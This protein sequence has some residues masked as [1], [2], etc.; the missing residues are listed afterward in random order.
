MSI[1]TID[2]AELRSL[3]DRIEQL[4]KETLHVLN[5]A[6]ASRINQLSDEQRQAHMDRFSVGDKVSFT[7][8]AGNR[9]CATVIRLNKKTASLVTHDDKRWNVAPGLLTLETE[10][11]RKEE[12]TPLQKHQPVELSVLPGGG[13][14]AGKRSPSAHAKDCEWVGGL[15]EVPDYVMQGDK[16]QRPATIVWVDS[17]GMIQGMTVCMPGEESQQI[18]S[19]LDEAFN[20]PQIGQPRLPTRIRTANMEMAKRLQNHYDSIEVVIAATPELDELQNSMY[21][22]ANREQSPLTYLAQGLQAGAIASFFNSQ[23]MLYKAAPWDRIPTDEC[24]FSVTIESLNVHNSVL[25]VIGQAGMDFGLLL[26]DSIGDFELY[27][28]AGDY[29]KRQA[30]DDSLLEHFHYR[31]LTF[32][33][34]AEIDDD[35]RKEIAANNWPVANAHAYPVL[36]TPDTGRFIRPLTDKDLDVFDALAQAVVYAL[37]NIA[38]LKKSW[39]TGERF[40]QKIITT[41]YFGETVV[42]LTTPFAYS[43]DATVHTSAIQKMATLIRSTGEFDWG[44]HDILVEEICRKFQESPECEKLG[45]YAAHCDLLMRFTQDYCEETIATAMPS[46]IEEVLFEVFP[47]KVMMNPADAQEVILEI[48]ALYHFLKR[49]FA[50][51]QA[52]A[53]LQLLSD[54]S[55]DRLKGALSDPSKA[56]M[57][58]S[59]LNFAADT[60]FDIES[61]ERL[62][63]FMNEA[64]GMRIPDSVIPGLEPAGKHTD[65]SKDLNKRKKKRKTSRKAQKKNR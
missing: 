10:T 32:E 65:A 42:E 7:D 37:K 24:L 22:H 64:Q 48:R 28:L 63:R 31:A 57:G 39:T 26:F 4:D 9:V 60:G 13:K 3:L 52:D 53:C 62:E 23:A 45:F 40:R 44:E 19:S 34:G 43:T 47:R 59:L 38:S 29:A 49:E 54:S 51:T 50:L 8:K 27:I 25:S 56:G 16:P 12:N 14:P 18:I 1:F 46:T 15:V 11:A 41:T 61:P 17:E 33:D 2:S 35:L 55:V 5:S 30:L 6:I 21:E 58:K 20:T 36:F